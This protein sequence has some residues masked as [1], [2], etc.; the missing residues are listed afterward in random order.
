[1][2][3]T[4]SSITPDT[5]KAPT[6]APSARAHPSR[7]ARALVPSAVALVLAAA[8]AGCSYAQMHGY[9]VVRTDTE[10]RYRPGAVALLPAVTPPELTFAAELDEGTRQGL[11]RGAPEFARAAEAGTPFSARVHVEDAGVVDGR[12]RVAARIEIAD[13]SGQVRTVLRT[14]HAVEGTD[15][16][17]AEQIG[18][19]FGARLGHYLRERE[20]YH[21][22]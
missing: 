15:A 20:R 9:S 19:A 14:E 16:A 11:D 21:R 6:S 18:H 5:P 13:R 22:W 12:L 7:L 8:G 4:T 17:A 3:D 10:L 1:M 2:F